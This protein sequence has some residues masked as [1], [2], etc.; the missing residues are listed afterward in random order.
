MECH[1]LLETEYSKPEGDLGKTETEKH[2]RYHEN[3]RFDW[4]S[5]RPRRVTGGRA[6]LVTSARVLRYRCVHA[7]TVLKTVKHSDE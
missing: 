6:S 1:R 4:S 5:L 3:K 2:K 7:G